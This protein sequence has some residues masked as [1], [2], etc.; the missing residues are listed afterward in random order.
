[1][2]IA[3]VVG[4]AGWSIWIFLPKALQAGRP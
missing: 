3:L 1:V 4:L 2:R